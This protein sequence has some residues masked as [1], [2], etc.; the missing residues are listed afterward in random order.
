MNLSDPLY[1]PG[2]MVYVIY[3]NPHIQNVANIQSAAVV[4]DPENPGKMALF[5]YET[6][7]PLT[8]DTAVY[9]TEEEAEAAYQYYFGEVG[10]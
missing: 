4:H 1:A 3:R 6:Y 9:R 5:M 8:E 10:L 7:Y 2:E